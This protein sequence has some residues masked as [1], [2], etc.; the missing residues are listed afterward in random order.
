MKMKNLFEKILMLV[1]AGGIS[2]LAGATEPTMFVDSIDLA[3]GDISAAANPADTPR[4]TNLPVRVFVSEANIPGFMISRSGGVDGDGSEIRFSQN[5]VIIPHEMISAEKDEDGNYTSFS[6]WVKV[7]EVT[8]GTTIKMHWGCDDGKRPPVNRS[9]EVW[10]DYVGVWHE[11]NPGDQIV[12]DVS[13]NGLTATVEGDYLMVSSNYGSLLASEAKLF[14][15]TA[16]YKAKEGMTAPN[17]GNNYDNSSHLFG[18]WSKTSHTGWGGSFYEAN[19]FRFHITWINDKGVYGDDV[20]NHSNMPNNIFSWNRVEYT[21]A[22]GDDKPKVTVSFRND[23]WVPYSGDSYNYDKLCYVPNDEPMILSNVNYYMKEARLS[24]IPRSADWIEEEKKTLESSNYVRALSGTHQIGGTANY[25][26]EPPRV[27]SSWSNPLEAAAKISVGTPAW[28][29]STYT[30][31]D[32]SGSEVYADFTDIVNRGGY[33]TYAAIFETQAENGHKRLTE[34]LYF[35]YVDKIQSSTLRDDQVMIFN[36]AHFEGASNHDVSGQGLVGTNWVNPEVEHEDGTTSV[37]TRHL[38]HAKGWKIRYGT[39][40]SAKPREEADQP[41]KSTKNYLPIGPDGTISYWSSN[42]SA[43]NLSDA[44]AAILYN[45]ND[46]TEPAAV[47]SPLYLKGVGEIYFDAVNV[48]QA[49]RNRLELQYLA[50]DD[51]VADDWTDASKIKKISNLEVYTIREGEAS[52]APAIRSYVALTMSS[53]T[54]VANTSSFY[55]VRAILPTEIGNSPIRFRIA[56]TDS[57]W[58][59]G[60]DMTD[61]PG[62]ILVDNIL[63]CDP[64]MSI[65]L[66]RIEKT[67]NESEDFGKELLG[68]RGT[69]TNP[70][71]RAGETGVKAKVAVEYSGFGSEESS[72]SG[73]LAALVFNYR[74]RYLNHN[75]GD[76]GAW[77][78]LRMVPSEDSDEIFITEGELELSSKPCDVEYYFSYATSAMRYGYFDYYGLDSSI[79]FDVVETGSLI[80]DEGEELRYKAA[81]TP[82][83]GSDFFFRLREGASDYEKLEIVWK[84]GTSGEEVVTP[85]HLVDDHVWTGVM[86]VKNADKELGF[87]VRGVNRGNTG[88]LNYWSFGFDATKVSPYTDIATRLDDVDVNDETTIPEFKW[89]RAD[90]VKGT[91]QFILR[92]NDGTDENGGV[93]TLTRGDYQDF[94]HWTEVAAKQKDSELKDR[95]VALSGQVDAEGNDLGLSNSLEQKRYPENLTD[96][97]FAGWRENVSANELWR[98]T[99]SM[100]AYNTNVLS[101]VLRGTDDKGERTLNNGWTGKNFMY[102]DES[103]NN[104]YSTDY[105]SRALLLSGQ[106]LGSLTCDERNDGGIFPDGLG[107]IKFDARLGQQHS[108]DRIAAYSPWR[109]DGFTGYDYTISARVA[110]TT[111]E[112]TSSDLGFDG[113]GTV[114]L[115]SYYSSKGAYEFRTKRVSRDKILVGLYRWYEDG[116]TIKVREL[117]STERNANGV[118]S[119]RGQSRAP[120]TVLCSANPN[121]AYVAFFSVKSVLNDDGEVIKNMLFAGFTNNNGTDDE[122]NRPSV[123]TDMTPSKKKHWLWISAVDTT[124]ALVGGVPGFVSTDCP[125]SFMRPE[126]RDAFDREITGNN[127]SYGGRNVDD[128]NFALPAVVTTTTSWDDEAKFAKRWGAGKSLKHSSWT[129]NNQSG[130]PIKYSGLETTDVYQDLVISI[131]V[132]GSSGRE[133]MPLKTERINTFKTTSYTIP[134][135]TTEPCHISIVTARNDELP[136]YDVILDNLELT[137]WH[138]TTPDVSGDENDKF[139][140]TGGWITKNDDTGRIRAELW[141]LRV[142]ETDE[143]QSIRSPYLEKGVGAITFSYDMKT[144]SDDAKLLVEVATNNVTSGMVPRLTTRTEGWTIL[145]TIEN[146]ELQSSRG[147]ITKYYG[148]RSG[149]SLIR[150]RVPESV[151]TE[152]H[153]TPAAE[154]TD[155][156]Q[157][158]RIDITSIAV[159]DEPPIDKNAWFAWN[160]RTAN[161]NTAFPEYPAYDKL[162]L[163]DSWIEESGLSGMSMELNNSVVPN[164]LVEPA[165]AEIVRQFAPYVQSPI[166]E[167]VEDSQEVSIGEISFRAR[168]SG[169][170]VGA[171]AVIQVCAVRSDGTVDLANPISEDIVIDSNE[172]KTYTVENKRSGAAA[173]RLVMKESTQSETYD[174]AV[175]DEVYVTERIV[176]SVIF[177]HVR[178]FR[179]MLENFEEIDDIE[180]ADEQPLCDEEWGVQCEITLQQVEKV[181]KPE[182]IRVFCEYYIEKYPNL[183][184]KPDFYANWG[185]KNWVNKP[186]GDNRGKIEL[187][188]VTTIDGRLIY[189][190]KRDDDGVSGY[191]RATEEA[192][193]VAQFHLYAT[194]ETSQDDKDDPGYELHRNDLDPKKKDQWSKPSWYDPSNLNAESDTFNTDPDKGWAAYTILDKVAPKRAWINEVE[195]WDGSNA[196]SRADSWIE[197]AIPSGVDMTG[198]HLDAVSWNNGSGNPDGIATYNIMQFGRDDNS[199]DKDGDGEYAFYV[200]SLPGATIPNDVAADAKLSI[201]TPIYNEEIFSNSRF[202]TISAFA[203]RLVRP[204]GIV[205]HEIVVSAKTTPANA[206]IAKVYDGLISAE[207][208]TDHHNAIM[209]LPDDFVSAEP[210][211][212]GK[213]TI[214][215]TNVEAFADLTASDKWN[216]EWIATPGAINGEQT[217]KAGYRIYPNNNTVIVNA[218]VTGFG[219]KHRVISSNYST[220]SE[221]A[222]VTKNDSA[223]IYYQLDPW[224]EFESITVKVRGSSAEVDHKADVNFVGTNAEHQSLYTL[225]LGPLE[226]SIVVVATAKTNQKLSDLIAEGYDGAE[227]NP[228]APAILE[229]MRT[230]Y[231]DVGEDEIKLIDYWTGLSEESKAGELTLTEMYWLGVAPNTENTV[232]RMFINGFGIDENGV[233]LKFLPHIDL[234]D[235]DSDIATPIT[236]LASKT[237]GRYSDEA[238]YWSEH[239]GWNENGPTMKIL[240]AL[241]TT[242]LN[243]KW[244]GNEYYPVAYYNFNASSFDSSCERWVKILDP[245]DETLMNNDQYYWYK[246]KDVE[247]IRGSILYTLSFN[248]KGDHGID[249]KYIQKDATTAP[250]TNP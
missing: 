182:T 155:G 105:L 46:A 172:W 250:S 74:N 85:M 152:A 13:G 59:A 14:S 176:P 212:V 209:A 35:A 22:A 208:N 87:K 187:F 2:L 92:F 62:K 65:A 98:E 88:A 78:S 109:G 103:L 132:A 174:R 12:K 160:V 26:I 136:R 141:P 27:K 140:Y 28:G 171:D 217:I 243:G 15:F 10:S 11:A 125:A 210:E 1:A 247:N 241:N 124:D 227:K 216:N 221:I 238:E 117:Y 167:S 60:T 184:G 39:I 226:E 230:E 200:A 73:T 157:C 67:W 99:F 219:L 240:M 143:I 114:S 177:S 100:N 36:D 69:L 162:L 242:G 205:D 72:R 151:I 148:L 90:V 23:S 145:D 231:P 56:R 249:V 137:Q 199:A 236:K 173:I 8:S 146:E 193:S 81:N 244:I 139:V 150:I 120:G 198:W 4:Y 135:Y 19:R 58:G 97:A 201:P 153:F 108:I 239:G 111:T 118:E 234:Y 49:Y 95:F 104:R 194:F 180:S 42:Q 144:L 61:G 68:D 130:D 122:G 106:G 113:Q 175:I 170:E 159:W 134:A 64:K 129:V 89:L 163:F 245:L 179:N 86:S 116:N 102:V 215:M 24:K 127:I 232:F 48:D 165:T 57:N 75:L 18:S 225:T 66:K 80:D 189:R 196:E 31:T 21:V 191:V 110:M 186:E 181:I 29:E 197:L 214:N 131:G 223:V 168:K 149:P 107:E 211:K 202:S 185:Y 192:G 228:Y 91:R 83:C 123:A 38:N 16:S 25:W 156:G 188:P 133:W 166:I 84:L 51:A 43:E 147:T 82:A 218:S 229:W 70:F 96:S 248:D 204:T 203:L 50:G 37:E 207:N 169:A 77:K 246:Y 71:P 237:Y 54:G 183:L 63:V 52:A 164:D 53:A 20:I 126:I 138:A 112:N 224:Y 213:T 235:T 101:N 32:A 79:D 76:E 45:H 119:D 115:F 121:K 178:P 5:G 33:G 222:S 44:G 142:A 233:D 158:G 206:S 55:R 17:A 220:A 3:V 93:M 30:L 94:N 6:F 7:P 195:I 9:R 40:G 154:R 190:A 161:K 47:Y 41:L 128:D 34:K